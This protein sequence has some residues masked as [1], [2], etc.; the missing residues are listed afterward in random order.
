MA[1]LTAGCS[2]PP[3]KNT[4]DAEWAALEALNPTD[5]AISAVSADGLP[6]ELR[7]E[8]LREAMREQCLSHRFAP[9]AFE[10]VDAGHPLEASAGGAGASGAAVRLDLAIRSFESDRYSITEKIRVIGQF[11]FTDA[12][13][14]N[15]VATVSSDLTIDLAA[16]ARRGAS[17]DEVV[18][19]AA[20]Q[21]VARS[22]EP[23][24][25]RRVTET[26]ASK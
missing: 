18:R 17:F 25:S 10:Y 15:T 13:T 2:A 16:E 5:V 8:V 19:A 24:P 1:L 14:G 11:L 7:P 4:L 22:L 6:R 23:M 9:I 12:A 20:R 21:F 3:P 26:R